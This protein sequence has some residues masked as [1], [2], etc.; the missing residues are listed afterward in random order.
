MV[1][2]SVVLYALVIVVFVLLYGCLLYV[3]LWISGLSN[4]VLVGLLWLGG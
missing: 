2:N 4:F 3:Y 1:V